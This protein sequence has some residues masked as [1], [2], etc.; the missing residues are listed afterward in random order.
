LISITPLKP[1][2]LRRCIVRNTMLSSVHPTTVNTT[3]ILC[4]FNVLALFSH[5]AATEVLFLMC[6]WFT[7]GVNKHSTNTWLEGS[8][9]LRFQQRV[10]E[11]ATLRN[12]A[13]LLPS[14]QLAAKSVSTAMRYL[15]QMHTPRK[16]EMRNK[17]ILFLPNENCPHVEV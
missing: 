7:H 16:S 4:L 2:F 11:M 15:V 14:I 13:T 17:W 5:V 10:W 1:L 6:S 12:A 3:G 8:R 9:L